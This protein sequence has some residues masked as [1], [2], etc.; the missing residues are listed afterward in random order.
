MSSDSVI[1]P[2]AVFNEIIEELEQASADADSVRRLDAAL[3]RIIRILRDYDP[4][5]TPVGHFK[6]ATAELKKAKE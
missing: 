3:I 5:T 6:K 2:R 4:D 1:L